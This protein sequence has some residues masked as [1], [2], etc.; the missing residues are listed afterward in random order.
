MNGRSHFQFNC[1]C[2]FVL[3]GFYFSFFRH[4][5]DACQ[6]RKGL[7]ISIPYYELRVF[8]NEE[9]IR[10]KKQIHI[11]TYVRLCNWRVLRLEVFKSAD[12]DFKLTFD[13]RSVIS[14]SFPMLLNFPSDER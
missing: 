6:N 4:D 14:K 5:R 10:P 2:L 11:H 1:F 3:L 9:L 8:L 12:K 13:A 7:L